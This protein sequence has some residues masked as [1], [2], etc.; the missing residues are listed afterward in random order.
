MEKKSNK[1]F[2]VVIG[3]LTVLVVLLLVLVAVLL[4]GEKKEKQTGTGNAGPFLKED[5]TGEASSESTT[6][7]FEKEVDKE[8][9]TT[10]NGISIVI[11]GFKFQVPSDYGCTYGEGIGPVVYLDDVFQMKLAVRDNSYEELMKNPDIITEKAISAGGEILQA[12]KETELK[13]NKYAYYRLDLYGDIC[14]VVYTNAPDGNGRF[15]GQIVIQKEDLSDEELLNMF[16][17]V[18]STAQETEDPDSTLDDIMAQVIASD[19]SDL[20]EKKEESTLKLDGESVTFLVPENFYSQ[21][22]DEYSDYSTENFVSKEYAI[23]VVCYL[24]AAG[25]DAGYKNARALIEA[26]RDWKYD[27]AGENTELQ[28]I[29]INGKDWYAFSVSYEYNGS[30]YQYVYAACDVGEDSIYYVKASVIDEDVKLSID[31]IRDFMILK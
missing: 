12:V 2:F 13:G 23:S 24:Q 27:F 30:D 1:G 16:A 5:S 9:E 31:T 7:V 8:K 25:G 28:T 26:E 15:A 20:G 6:D 18:I 22:Q 10:G 3:I 17:G 11:D 4:L 19:T 21:G 14:F 29:D